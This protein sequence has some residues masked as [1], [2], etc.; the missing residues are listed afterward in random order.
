MNLDK[1]HYN[2]DMYSKM[3]DLI[4]LIYVLNRLSNN[5]NVDDRSK[6]YLISML[7]DVE[8]IQSNFDKYRYKESYYRNPKI[9]SKGCDG[10]N[11]DNKGTFADK[12]FLFL[13]SL[14]NE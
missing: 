13:K 6:Q 1:R 12:I 3:Y 10:C 8:S 14:N 9:S 2:Q 11:Y 5:S 4:E 7:N